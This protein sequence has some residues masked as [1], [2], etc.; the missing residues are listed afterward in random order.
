MFSI[1]VSLLASVDTGTTL[2]VSSRF[3][4]ITDVAGSE[5]RV[6][7]LLKFAAFTTTKMSMPCSC[8]ISVC[9]ATFSL[10]VLSYSFSRG[11]LDEEH[12]KQ[13]AIHL[14]II[15]RNLHFL[16]GFTESIS[17]VK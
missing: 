5:S 12:P 7:I 15:T 11:H 4:F 16:H 14:D 10:S 6:C 2:Y 1:I 13:V 17:F 8:R 3:F 9:N